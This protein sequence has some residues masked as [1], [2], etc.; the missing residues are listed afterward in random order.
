MRYIEYEKN[1]NS[2][3]PFSIVLGE[4]E[5]GTK[6]SLNLCEAPHILLAGCTGSG[7]SVLIEVKGLVKKYGDHTAVDHLDFTIEPGKIYGFLAVTV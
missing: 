1:I 4:K 2:D 6:Y 5:D 7:K 3:N